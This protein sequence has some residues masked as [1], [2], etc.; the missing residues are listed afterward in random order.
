MSKGVCFPHGSVVLMNETS[1][2]LGEINISG[3]NIYW[4][5]V[6]YSPSNFQKRQIHLQ[7]LSNVLHCISYIYFVS[8]LK[9]WL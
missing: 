9:L 8:Y 4:L 5:D 3:S 7:F 6:L 2:M 1:V